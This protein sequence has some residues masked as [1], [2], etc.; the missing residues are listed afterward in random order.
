M[1]TTCGSYALKRAK[2]CKDAA[3]VE[4]LEKAGMII[5]AKTNLSVCSTD[6]RWTLR[7]LIRLCRS[8]V[9]TKAHVSL[10]VGRL[11]VDRYDPVL[12]HLPVSKSKIPSR[13]NHPMSEAASLRMRL[14]WAIA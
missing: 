6:L 1:D 9:P 2:A 4:M 14:S 7:S 12:I 13:R 5:I 11:S 10:R 3:I 8:W